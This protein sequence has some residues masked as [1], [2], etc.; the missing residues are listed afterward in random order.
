MPDTIFATCLRRR[1]C[2]L[3]RMPWPRCQVDANDI[4]VKLVESLTAGNPKLR[5][6]FKMTALMIEKIGQSLSMKDP[7]RDVGHLVSPS[8]RTQL[9]TVASELVQARR[10]TRAALQK[11]QA[12]K[13]G[14]DAASVPEGAS[15]KEHFLLSDWRLGDD[16]HLE[17]KPVEGDDAEESRDRPRSVVIR[18]GDRPDS[19]ASPAPSPSPAPSDRDRAD[20][21]GADSPLKA[22]SAEAAYNPFASPSPEP[23]GAPDPFAGACASSSP[24]PFLPAPPSPDPFADAGGSPPAAVAAARSGASGATP[25]CVPAPAVPPASKARPPTAVAGAVAAAVGNPFADDLNP[26]SFPVD[27]NPFAAPAS[28]PDSPPKTAAAASASFNPF[29]V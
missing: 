14:E 7:I 26:F 3:L 18:G 22:V 27:P 16:G 2:A 9:A 17:R 4:L 11:R 21:T 13:A 24:D 29:D 20:P 10:K 6:P 12:S 5:P 1:P 8:S 25:A 19:E 15:E 23:D 28:P